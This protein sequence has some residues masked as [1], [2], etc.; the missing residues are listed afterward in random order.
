MFDKSAVRKQNAHHSVTKITPPPFFLVFCVNNLTECWL[1]PFYCV[2]HLEKRTIICIQ[3]RTNLKTVVLTHFVS[4]HTC[5]FTQ[6]WSGTLSLFHHSH[7]Q[8]HFCCLQ[9]NKHFASMG[10]NTERHLETF[11]SSNETLKPLPT[12]QCTLK[13]QSSNFVWNYGP[14]NTFLISSLLVS[15][16][17]GLVIVCR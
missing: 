4:C 6:H 10:R 3:M 2:L 15:N 8:N 7:F 17:A 14:R 12:F 13:H 1:S 11:H 16:K 5:S 9:M